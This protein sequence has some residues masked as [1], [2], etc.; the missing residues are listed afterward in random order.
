MALSNKSISLR[1]KITISFAIIMTLTILIITVFV[2][3]TFESE[4]GKYVDDNNKAEVKHLVTFD[5]K[6]IYIDDQWDINIIE[7]LCEDSIEKGIALEIYDTN[8]NII[9]GVLKD[10]KNLSNE[11]LNNIRENMQSIEEN[12]SPKLKEYKVDIYD[13]NNN[14]VGYANILYYESIYYMENDIMF[15][16]IVNTF[17]QI[18]SVISIG[19]IIIISIIISKSIS[20][21]IEKVSIMAKA[22]GDGKYKNKVDYKNNI[23]EVKELVESINKLSCKLSEQEQLRKRITTDV[24]H[25]LRTPLTSIQGHLDAIIDGIWEATPERL[26]SIREEVTRLSDLVGHLRLLSKFDS[27]KNILNKTN[28]NLKELIQNIIYNYE[29]N[30]LEKNIKIKCNIDDIYIRLDKNQFSQVIINLL[31]NAIKYTFENGKIDI[32]VYQENNNIIIS[33]KDNGIGIPN[34]DREFIFERFYRTDKSRDKETGGIGIGLTI[35]KSIVN[36][37]NGEIFVNSKLNEGT[38]F[39]IKLPK[40]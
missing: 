14:I 2:R 39:I 35:S 13:E 40:L 21:P 10:N 28:T 33:F 19:S 34:E 18:I 29:S 38:E 6:K 12:W 1:N 23:K 32:K 8:S 11:I 4:F 9:Y 37:H 24:A 31:S 20:N 30:A 17:M 15:L 5:L 22:I 3:K 36:A 27:E 7:K 25:E 16:N 26:I